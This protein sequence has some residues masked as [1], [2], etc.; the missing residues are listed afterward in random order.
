MNRSIATTLFLLLIATSVLSQ[1]AAP[2]TALPDGVKL[3]VKATE[4][5]IQDHLSKNNTVRLLVTKNLR[6]PDGSVVIPENAVATARVLE[7]EQPKKKN[8]AKLLLVVEKAKWKG[9]ELPLHAYI[10]SPI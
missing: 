3:Q 7:T 10:V 4:D 8:P 1:T 9:G 2:I 5:I 6:G